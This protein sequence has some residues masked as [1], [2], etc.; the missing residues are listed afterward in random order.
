[1]PACNTL[2]GISY[3]ESTVMRQAINSL[4]EFIQ[5]AREFHLDLAN[6]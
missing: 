1:M 2:L 4:I 6:Q 3:T 5:E